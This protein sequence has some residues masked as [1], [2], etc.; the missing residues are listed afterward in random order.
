MAVRLLLDLWFL[1]VL[2]C[3]GFNRLRGQGLKKGERLHCYKRVQI[4]LSY[5]LMR[6]ECW[7]VALLK[8]K[9]VY[10]HV[11]NEWEDNAFLPSF[12]PDSCTGW[13]PNIIPAIPSGPTESINCSPGMGGGMDCSDADKSSASDSVSSANRMF[14]ASPPPKKPESSYGKT[15]PTMDTLPQYY[16]AQCFAVSHQEGETRSRLICR[17]S[18]TTTHITFRNNVARR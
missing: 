17:C 3:P 6:F 4:L 10:V 16:A 5:P 1:Y 8:L 9:V 12:G 13:W 11:L 7:V 14:A 18:L 2:S 15:R